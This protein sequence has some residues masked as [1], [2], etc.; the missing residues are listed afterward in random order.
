MGW[1][2]GLGTIQGGLVSVPSEGL[3][4]EAQD[5]STHSVDRPQ[6]PAICRH[7]HLSSDAF[8]QD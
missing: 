5:V 6:F 3:H 4:G 1:T 7:D 2:H 8:A